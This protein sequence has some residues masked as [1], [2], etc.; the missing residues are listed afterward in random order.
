MTNITS[1]VLSDGTVVNT[2]PGPV[3][4]ELVAR[5]FTELHEQAEQLCPNKSP[6]PSAKVEDT[7]EPA[8][9]DLSDRLVFETANESLDYD[10]SSWD[11]SSEVYDDSEAQ[12][13]WVGFRSAFAI[14]PEQSITD[15][16]RIELYEL[17][18]VVERLST[19]PTTGSAPVAEGWQLT[20]TKN[21][22]ALII[23]MERAENK[24]YLPDSIKE[25]WGEFMCN[26]ARV[27]APTIPEASPK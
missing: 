6:A 2:F 3:D 14:L 5:A 24:G 18:D 12:A 1:L 26:P 27:A 16:E 4:G 21:L 10:F 23:A 19:A 13:A 11:E 15:H 17:R 8:H 22:D 25:A 20:E 7:G 9:H